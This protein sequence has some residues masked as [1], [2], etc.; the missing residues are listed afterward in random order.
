MNKKSNSDTPFFASRRF[1]IIISL[2]L[3]VVAWLVVT[4]FIDPESNGRMSIPVD[5]TYNEASYATQGLT[6]VDRPSRNITV[7][8]SG[9]RSV[10]NT[11]TQSDIA[12]YPDY[13]SVRGAGTYNL[14]LEV[15]NVT[16]KSIELEQSD[17]YVTV[18][19]DRLTTRKFTISVN[20]A[21]I[22]P[23]E[24][25][26]MDLPVV[27]PGEVTLTGPEQVLARIDDVCVNITLNEERTESA[28]ITTSLVYLDANGEQVISSDIQADVTQA[29]VTVPIYQT[30]TLPL[31]IEYTSVP[32][33][34]DPE[35][36]GATLSEK[37]I[38][39][40]GP[41]ALLDALSG[42][43]AA[44]VDL[45]AFTLGEDITGNITLP[46]GVRNI[47]NLQTV[48]VHFQT[49]NY[50]TRTLNVTELRVIN[51]PEGVEIT[52]PSEVVNNVTLVGEADELEALS[53]TGVIAQVDAAAGNLSVASG[54]QKI[55]VQIVIP[56][57]KT[58]FAT[59]SYTVMCE[60]SAADNSAA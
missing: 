33:G 13:S 54:Q 49:D 11:L 48:T 44:Y 46:E 28:I 19:F 5:F 58:V 22:V 40:A 51:A 42:I 20:A 55:P 8:Y 59:G 35:T 53:A 10:I 32:L 9:D 57:T 18:T 4:K 31:S 16:N 26:Y 29:E 36:L 6:I 30:K 14:K 2:V 38:R 60:V 12:V 23:A 15:R 1:N 24:G 47:D 17:A 39:V 52:F 45:A 3:A 34:F 7:R 43:T 25:Y 27:A 21:G 50:E 56:S 41:T 37:T